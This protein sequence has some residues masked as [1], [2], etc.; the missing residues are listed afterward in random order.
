MSSALT[1]DELH[2]LVQGVRFVERMT[3]VDKNQLAG[4]L[5]EMR[6]IF[7]GIK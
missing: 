5:T 3:P 4:E 7:A 6:R 1:I 2:Q